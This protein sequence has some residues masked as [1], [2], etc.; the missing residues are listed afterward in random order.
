MPMFAKLPVLIDRPAPGIA[1]AQLLDGLMHQAMGVSTEQAIRLLKKR[2]SQEVK[3]HRVS[4]LTTWKSAELSRKKFDVQPAIIN[5]ERRYPAG[6]RV[7][8]P[9][10]LVELIDQRDQLYCMLP[11]FDEVLYIPE[12]GLLTTILSDTVRSLTSTLSPRDLHKLWPPAESEMRW[13]RLD[14]VSPTNGRVDHQPRVLSSVAE[15]MHDSRSLAIV[16]GSRDETLRQLRDTLAKGSCLVIGETGVGKTTLISSVARELFLARRSERKLQRRKQSV[17]GPL[18]PMFWSSSAGRLI[19]GMRYLGQWQQR[20]EEVVAALAN[21]DGVLAIENLLDLVSVGGR[22]PRDSLAA[23]LVPYLRSGSLRMVAEANPTELDACR[24]LLPALVDALPII[25]VE[26]MQQEHEQELLRLTLSNQLQSMDIKFDPAI[27]ACISRLCRQYQR[28]NAAPGPSMKFVQELIGRRRQTEFTDQRMLR[29][30]DGSPGDAPRALAHSTDTQQTFLQSSKY[31]TVSW[32]LQ[33]FSQRTGLPLK[34]LD[35]A[36][37][38]DRNSVAWELSQD[39]IGQVHAC[40]QVAGIVTRI[41]SALQD[42]R[43]PFGCLLLCGPTGV[44]KTQLAKSLAGYLFGAA[45][46][47]SS[48]I[49][50]DMSEYAGASAGFRL[51]HDS[52]GESAGWIQQIRARP[53]SVL[54][55]DE[56]EKAALEVF[57]ILL[58]VLDEGRLT[59]RLGRVTS[60]RNSVIVMTSNIGAR[61]TSSLGFGDEGQVDYVGEVRKAFRPEFFNRLDG[62]IPFF[63]LSAQAMTQIVVKELQDLRRREGLQRYG[64]SIN[65]TTQLINHLSQTGFQAT[66]GARPLQ[67]IIETDVVAPLSKWI[68]ER[69]DRPMASLK[70]DWDS[71]LQLLRVIS[72]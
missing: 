68:V 8:L 51:L 34:L 69:G 36:Q 67:R 10:R 32:I 39:V 1:I 29:S 21:I 46:D 45:T 26:P 18:L 47:K 3:K 50:L 33:R 38:L 24:R 13:M 43:R 19:A 16:P 49:R 71:D 48:M 65:W 6:P 27:P 22:E 44:G 41:K 64:R 30:L 58:S 28:H 4:S 17:A 9:V 14:L 70:L 60:F 54:L 40:E 61:N 15:P 23:F 35:D 11:D 53:L 2:L 57:D 5:K 72:E 42:P 31:W 25:R 62:V 52:T 12:R 59:D 56:V 55:L 66:L 37:T 63:P 7:Q 20:L